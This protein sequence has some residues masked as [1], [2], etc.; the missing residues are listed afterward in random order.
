MIRIRSLE[1]A[2]KDNS[3]SIYTYLYVDGNFDFLTNISQFHTA[4]YSPNDAN[5]DNAGHNEDEEKTRT[6]ANETRLW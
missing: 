1:D 2:I 6:H 3:H 5:D 4:W